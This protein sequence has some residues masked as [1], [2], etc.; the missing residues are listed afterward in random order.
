MT[1]AP[2]SLPTRPSRTSLYREAT[3]LAIALRWA[4]LGA[5]AILLYPDY[6]FSVSAVW[7][8]G[9]LA[10]YNG[11]LTLLFWSRNHP[12]LAYVCVLDLAAITAL[13]ILHGGPHGDFVYLYTVLIVV[14]ALAYEWNGV[15]LGLVAYVIGEYT[16][17][18]ISTSGATGALGTG[19]RV[20]AIALAA[21]VIG[22]LV[23]RHEAL[24]LRLSRAAVTDDEG[25]VYDLQ[26]FAKALENLHKL[27]IRGSWPYSVLVI[28]ITK[29]GSA[30]GYRQPRIEDE[31]LNGLAAETRSELRSTDLVGRVGADVFGVALPDT[32]Q[33][34]AEN[35]AQRV[36][37]RL[38][39]LAADLDIAVGL[40]SIEPTRQDNYDKCLHAA[41]AAAR[42]AKAGSDAPEN[43]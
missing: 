43:R 10:L 39:E 13:L 2:K 5:A 35:V 3:A 34:G 38:R 21:I 33:A 19:M 16:V 20:G 22:R 1:L 41:F 9:G 42:E 28:D 12:P 26:A 15:A 37:Q 27:A 23:E 18:M 7:L 25:G 29:P 31:T 36:E 32:G 24:R 8:L 11:L 6:G 17:S 14:L 40:A 4:L 30:G